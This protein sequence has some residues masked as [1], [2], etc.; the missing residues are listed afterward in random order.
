[1]TGWR[2]LSLLCPAYRGAI[3]QRPP[4]AL[5]A[6]CG[7]AYPEEGGVLRLLAGRQA[8]AGYDPHFFATLREVED[9]HFWFVARRQVVLAALRRAVPGLAGRRLFDVGCGSGGLL[10]FLARNGIE[11]AGA[12]D[13]YPESLR[14]VRARLELPL[15]L[16]DEGRDPPLGPGHDLLGMFDVLEHVDDDVGALRALSLALRPGGALVLTVPAHP[17]LFDEMDELACHRRRYRRA[18]LRRVIEQAGLEVRLLSH[19]MSPLVPVLF[20]VRTLGR[21]ADEE[22]H[23]ALERRE[24]EFRVVPG[25]N[26]AMRGVLALERAAMRLTALP[27]G[28]SIVAVA[29]RPGP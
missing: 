21:L 3:E 8:A 28:S 15:V 16:V 20:L 18:G 6:R 7:A 27:F 12:C 9:R 1:L 11:I 25:L 10:A 14:L 19:F 29:V 13:V 23:R 24:A 4:G 22:R 2:G 5:C 17:S 26:A